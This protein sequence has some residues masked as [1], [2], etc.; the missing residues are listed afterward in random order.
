MKL[1]VIG[2]NAAGLSA[3][4]KAKRSN[5]DIEVNVYERT[6]YT[7][8]GACGMPYFI[9]G[10]VEKAENLISLS[11]EALINKRGINAF[12][13]HEVQKIDTESKKVIVLNTK[14]GQQFEDSYEKLVLAMGA[15]AFI[16][17]I[18]GIKTSNVFVLKSI[19]DALAIKE[20]AKASGKAIIL[21]G[22]L[23]GLE[24]AEGIR[25]NGVDVH[26]VEMQPRLLPSFEDIYA[27]Q[28]SGV[29]KDEGVELSLGTSIQE[30]FS[31]DGAFSGCRLSNGETIYGDFLV[32]SA[33]VRPNSKLAKEVGIELGTHGAIK[34][35][36]HMQTSNP[37]IYACGDCA[38]HYHI[39]T[40]QDC[41]IP[42]GTT[43]NKQGRVAGA[44]IAGQKSD[45]PGVIGAQATKVFG[46][47][48]ASCGLNVEQAAEYGYQPESNRI[49]KSSLSNYYPGGSELTLTLV[50]DKR[51]GLLLGAQGSGDESIA[52]RMNLLIAA[53]SKG[54]TVEELM[55][56]DL[57]YTPSVAPVYDAITIAAEQ[58]IKKVDG[59]VG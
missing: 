10:K 18:P 5:S 35:D 52:G 20:K 42:L 3:A 51:D 17:P 36:K 23:I 48:L 59:Y 47:F 33:G 37:D 26:I 55:R 34:V 54:M 32:V 31:E 56:L 50:F 6:G 44:N 14:T 40:K 7:S 58:A 43:A 30:V 22:G 1:V 57:V 45:F 8:Y 29:L 15:S 11:P 2:G 53:A 38:T 13:H 21:G 24:L 27:E 41:Y 25:K 16:P 46:L 9:G 28:V 4:S 19:E 39:L 49:K 12:I